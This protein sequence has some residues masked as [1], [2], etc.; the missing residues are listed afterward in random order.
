MLDE[1]E[2]RLL[3]DYQRS[4]PLVHAPFEEIARTLD[5]DE[6]WVRDR[7]GRWQREGSVS[8]V[9]AVFRPHA[10]GVSTLASMQVPAHDLERVAAIVS[11]FREVNHNYEREHRRNL[12]FVVTARDAAALEATLDALR[13]RTGYAV[14]SLP[15]VAEYW[16]DLGFRLD[17]PAGASAAAGLKPAGNGRCGAAAVPLSDE[18]RL[19]IAALEP[20]LPLVHAPYAAVAEQAGVAE[21]EV[22]DRIARWMDAGVIKRLGVVVRHR[23]FGYTANAMCVWDV[24]DAE[25]D[26]T[27][28]AIAGEPGVSLCYARERALPDWPYN[29]YCMVHGRDRGQVERLVAEMAAWHG[30]DRYPCA[31]LFS[32][33]RFKQR[34][35]H[36]YAAA[37]DR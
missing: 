30:L 32:R 22:L 21:S 4:F 19:V 12:W 34:G 14:V 27:G 36:Y 11:S 13:E 15:L 24:P 33:R 20:G 3:N 25:V 17:W 5:V 16:I 1:R 2:L 26:A 9:G 35:A 7:L 29:L 8:R 18:D 23:E 31:I 10:I 28:Q 6:D 37:G